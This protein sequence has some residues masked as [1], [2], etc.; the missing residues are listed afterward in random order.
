[1]AEVKLKCP[2]CGRGLQAE[3]LM[4]R[5]VGFSCVACGIS[6]I[7]SVLYAEHC[8]IP[9]EQR[10]VNG[11]SPILLEATSVEKKEETEK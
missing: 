9:V 11:R 6:F 3:H 10:I 1:M 8:T 2:H 5:I 7:F 4:G